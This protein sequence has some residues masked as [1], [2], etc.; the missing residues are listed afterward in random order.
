MVKVPGAVIRAGKKDRLHRRY[1]G[2]EQQP[3]TFEQKTKAKSN[4][5][6]ALGLSK[7][8]VFSPVISKADASFS[9][10][11]GTVSFICKAVIFSTV[12]SDFSLP[13]LKIFSTRARISLAMETGERL[14]A[15]L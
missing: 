10:G 3:L 8:G 2:V 5:S 9:A 4:G 7:E 12:F 11:T 6:Y 13:A 15:M 14:P 1:S